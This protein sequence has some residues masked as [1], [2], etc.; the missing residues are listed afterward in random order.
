MKAL[1]DKGYWVMLVDLVPVSTTES[2]QVAPKSGSYFTPAEKK[3][4]KALIRD[5]PDLSDHMEWAYFDGI[6]YGKEWLT[7]TK[8]KYEGDGWHVAT[9]QQKMQ[10]MLNYQS[11]TT[12]YCNFTN[13]S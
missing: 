5:L 8:F 13:V 3:L 9:L 11:G 7:G 2:G 12:L 1:E 10:V 4:S 6:T